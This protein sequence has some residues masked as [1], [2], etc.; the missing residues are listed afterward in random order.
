MIVTFGEWVALIFA[1]CALVLAL[2]VLVGSYITYRMAFYRNPKKHRAN[3]YNG[4]KNDGSEISARSKAMVDNILSLQFEDIYTT[5]FDGIPLRARLYLKDSS[6]P[7]AIQVHGYKSTPMLDFSGGGQLALDLGMN[8]IM[9]DQR[10]HGESGGRCIS[11]GHNEKRDLLS[12]ID[13]VISRFGEGSEIILFGISMGGATVILASELD[14]PKN[15]LGVFA[16]CPYSSA[17]D[18][19][20]KTASEMH[21]PKRAAYALSRLGARIFG[22]FDPDEAEP[23]RAIKNAR[24]PI[25]I[26]H[27]EKDSFVPTDMSRAMAEA[28]PIVELHTFP[29]ADHGLSYLYDSDRYRSIVKNGVSSFLKRDAS[30]NIERKP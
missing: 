3:P 2:G 29:N 20:R 21:L 27:G 23:I 1:L 17:A 8:V 11:F 30:V 26:V 7:F 19:I 15:V 14:L 9:I 28:N 16:D 5:S 13:Y 4:I 22:G 12:W 25:I 6:L 10:A 18:M 24:V